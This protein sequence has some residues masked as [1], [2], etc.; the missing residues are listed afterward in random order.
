MGGP[1]SYRMEKLRS[2]SDMDVAGIKY[3]SGSARYTRNFI[4][5]QEALAGGK[6]A[7]VVFGD[8]Q[9]MARVFV[10]GK[11]CGIVWTP[12][13]KACI[14]PYLKEG[15]NIIEV[16]VINTW[17]NRIVGDVIHPGEK[18]YARTNIKY[19]FNRESPLLESGLIGSATIFFKNKR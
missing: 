10:N 4:V 18:A 11:D 14:T 16:E 13:Y 5:N 3:Y 17:N 8:I 7:F 2:W 12:P 1:E 6:E 19:K 9:E 15:T